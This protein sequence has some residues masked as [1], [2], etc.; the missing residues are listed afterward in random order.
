VAA[1]QVDAVQVVAVDVE[2][3]AVDAEVNCYI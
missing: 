1:V 3:V 2:V